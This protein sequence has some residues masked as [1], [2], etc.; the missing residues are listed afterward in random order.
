MHLD[1]SPYPPC[2]PEHLDEMKEEAVSR[3]HLRAIG[4]WTGI[5][6]QCGV[7]FVQGTALTPPEASRIYP[8]GL[9]AWCARQRIRIRNFDTQPGLAGCVRITIG[10]ETEM[11]TLRSAASLKGSMPT[12][13]LMC[14]LKGC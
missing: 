3:G 14:G 7:G 11:E 5:E 4:Y 10:S 2:S 6:R 12:I 1:Q 9:V 8:N 13:E